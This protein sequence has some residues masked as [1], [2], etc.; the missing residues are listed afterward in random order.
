MSRL[1]QA[2]DSS[3]AS[4]GRAARAAARTASGSEAAG[5]ERAHPAQRAL[6]LGGVAPD[7]HR[8]AH[9]AAGGRRQRG[10]VLTLALPAQDHEQGA[11]HTGHRRERRPDVG[12]LGVIDVG[13]AAD[14]GHPLRAVSQ[15]G[16]AGQLRQHDRQRQPQG[17]P[18]R[19]RGEG[20]GRVVQALDL[21]SRHRQQRHPCTGEPPLPALLGHGEVG[22]DAGAQREAQGARGRARHGHHQRVIEV[23]H[24]RVAAREDARLGGRIAGQV[25][26]AIQVIGRH[27]QH[28]RGTAVQRAGRLQL[29]AGQLEHVQLGAGGEQIERRL[30]EVAADPHL[31]SRALRHVGEQGRHGA[32]AVGAGDPDHGG[33]CGA[34]EQ[35]DIADDLQPAPA[36][37]GE[38]RLG[39]GYPGGCHH[40]HRIGE[41]TGVE[42]AQ[43][44]RDPRI[45]GRERRQLRWRGARVGDRQ[46]PAVRV[47]VARAGQAAAAEAHDHGVG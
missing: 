34:G 44:Q 3:T 38:E 36:D 14:L 16:E 29:V 43:P 23:D 13:D 20:V 8:V 17:F 31:Q 26:V 46:A 18:E 10:E 35:L 2:G 32:L 45:E 1:A 19:Q 28:R 47:Q 37:L 9:L 11:G 30:A 40:A 6:E 22:A 4:P 39:Q 7:E 5:L 33:L 27:V 15:P 41:Q 12:A 21:H 25:R 24:R 42:P